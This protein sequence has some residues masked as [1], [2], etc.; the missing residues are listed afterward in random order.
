MLWKS[1][2]TTLSFS[3]SQKATNFSFY[4]LCLFIYVL[5]VLLKAS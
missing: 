4:F 2:N 1:Y 5:A 3:S